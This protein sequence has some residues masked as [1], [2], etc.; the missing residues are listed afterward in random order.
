MISTEPP[1]RMTGIEQP[2]HDVAALS[3]RLPQYW[4][5][6]PQPWIAQVNS[7]FAIARVTSQT[8]KFNHLVSPLP[9]KIA[10]ELRDL[11]LELPETDPFDIPTHALV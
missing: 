6:D 1:P 3:L 11:I 5:A 7:Q 9:P 10:T 4:P 2:Q 8:Q